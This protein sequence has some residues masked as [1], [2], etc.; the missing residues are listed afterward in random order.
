MTTSTVCL[1]SVSQPSRDCGESIAMTKLPG[2]RAE[3]E[4]PG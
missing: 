2:L 3:G 4:R 1:D